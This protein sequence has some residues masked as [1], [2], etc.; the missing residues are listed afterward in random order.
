MTLEFHPAVQ[1]D[2][3][4]AIDYYAAEGGG[5][6]ADRLEAEMRDC[7]AAI[8]SEPRQF[9][10]YQGTTAFRR[11]RLRHFPY[12]VVYREKLDVVRVTILK[13]EK[14]HPRFGMK[15]W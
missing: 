14:R 3:N 12:V 4:A 1:Q 11:I 10:F 9:A 5:H 2:F 8:K 13:H 7:L 6:L 15:R